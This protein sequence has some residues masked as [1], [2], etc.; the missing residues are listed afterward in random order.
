MSER[1]TEAGIIFPVEDDPPP[2]FELW[3]C[4][5]HHRE[6]VDVHNGRRRC[7]P[8]L[9]GIL[10]PCRA[11]RLVEVDG[12]ATCA[13][14]RHRQDWHRESAGPCLTMSKREGEPARPCD[15][16]AFSLPASGKPNP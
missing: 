13:R 1:R 6:A 9:G 15:C 16:R 7:D 12:V 4:R 5:S 14:C 8:K 3:W 2:P 10:L 11:V